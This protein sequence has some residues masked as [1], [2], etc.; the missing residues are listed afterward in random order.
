MRRTLTLLALPV[1]LLAGVLA[2]AASASAA[3]P[4][5]SAS[6]APAPYTVLPPAPRG[7]KAV[8]E[9]TAVLIAP[10]G[11][12]RDYTRADVVDALRRVDAF[13][14]SETGGLVGFT[15]V[16]VTDWV[17]PAD[18]GL[19]CHDPRAM[20][21]FAES[22]TGWKRGPDKHLMALVPDER[23]C[24]GTSNGEEPDGMDDGGRVYIANMTP[25]IIAHELG[26]NLS[27]AHASSVQCATGWDPDASRGL[28][29]SCSRS[30][31]G[32][33]SD[34]MG[35]SY[36]FY[37]FSAPSLDRFGLISH[38]AVPTCGATRRIPIQTMSAG[39][40]AQRVVSWK[41]PVRPSVTY[42]L[43]YRDRVDQSQYDAV[44]RSPNKVARAS[45]VQILR[46]DPSMP[47]GGSI[48][49]RPGDTGPGAELVRAG[50]HVPL[51]DG[52]SVTVVGIDETA[53]VATVDV[54]VPC[55]SGTSAERGPQGP[56]PADAERVPVVTD[57]VR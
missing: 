44:W 38:R 50:E 45:G 54:A 19:D 6:E 42:Y 5:P 10:A 33:H 34:V 46:T 43:Q 13:Y 36:A 25:G 39:F 18:A 14:R 7:A 29:A 24:G 40:D 56:A 11:T 17:Q 20:L 15:T 51:V 21:A 37:A 28:P 9:V 31:Y 3:G 23:Q 27:L 57:P 26:H 41:D 35:S 47:A 32:N 1:V 2:P 55:G 30:E 12:R 49:V 8:H 48:L 22:Q 53:H 16:S 4:P 52:M